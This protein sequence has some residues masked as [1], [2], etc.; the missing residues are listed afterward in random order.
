ME[1][2]H[3]GSHVPRLAHDGFRTRDD[4]TQGVQDSYD[5]KSNRGYSRQRSQVGVS[6][7]N[8]SLSTVF[9]MHASTTHT[10]E[11]ELHEPPPSNSDATSAPALVRGVSETVIPSSSGSTGIRPALDLFVLG[12]QPIATNPARIPTSRLDRGGDLPPAYEDVR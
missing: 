12:V 4:H 10:G 3:R 6:N 7:D 9:G 11:H 2:T 5:L 1:L 8:T